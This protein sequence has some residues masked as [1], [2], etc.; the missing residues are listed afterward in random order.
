MLLSSALQDT[1]ISRPQSLQFPW[2][3]GIWKQVFAEPGLD[4]FDS[5]FEDPKPPEW[6][7][8]VREPQGIGGLSGTN[9]LRV[10]QAN[11][12]YAVVGKIAAWC[13]ARRIRVSVENPLNCLAWL[14]DGLDDLLRIPDSC[15]VVFAHCADKKVVLGQEAG[16]RARVLLASVQRHEVLSWR[17]S[18]MTSP[19]L[20]ILLWLLH[21]S[22]VREPMADLPAT[23][24]SM[25]EA[26]KHARAGRAD[27]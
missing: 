12:L 11:L 17:R 13:F 9:L 16:R 27:K 7:E 21:K 19:L 23:V 15:Q 22:Q 14:C 4:L 18:A 26:L 2:E 3:R 1:S 25:Q 8:D 20:E 6:V 10:Q 5:A 24:S